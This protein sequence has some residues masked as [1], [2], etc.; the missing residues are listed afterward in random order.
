VVRSSGNP[1]AKKDATISPNGTTAYQFS[2][3]V[4]EGLLEDQERLR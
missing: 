3:S 1:N 2:E 4:Q